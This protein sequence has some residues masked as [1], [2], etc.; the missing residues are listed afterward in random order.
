MFFTFSKKII[1]PITNIDLK[2]QIQT[3]KTNNIS[4]SIPMNNMFIR[5]QPTN[6]CS[7]CNSYR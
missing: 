2:S 6:K 5:S 4:K 7:S 3:T 1:L